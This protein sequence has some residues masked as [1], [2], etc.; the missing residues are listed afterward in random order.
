MQTLV[1]AGRRGV[2]VKIE[3]RR[4]TQFLVSGPEPADRQVFA[5][6]RAAVRTF[7]AVEHGM[8]LAWRPSRRRSVAEHVG[9][10]LGAVGGRLP[11]YV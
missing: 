11:T 1:R 4:G 8:T 10:L 9:A 7:E 5:D 2:L 6:A 3:G